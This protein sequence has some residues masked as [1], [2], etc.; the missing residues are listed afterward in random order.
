MSSRHW[1]FAMHK[2][3]LNVALALCPIGA[4]ALAIGGSKEVV[5]T[6][7]FLEVPGFVFTFFSVVGTA[8]SVL[9]LVAF[10]RFLFEPAGSV[11]ITVCSGF[12]AMYVREAARRTDLPRLHM[13][14]SSHFGRDVPSVE[15]M[16]LWLARCATIF[17]LIHRVRRNEGLSELTGTFKFIPL[18]VAGVR[19]L[20]LGRVT[21]STFRPEHVCSCRERAA[22]CYVGDVVATTWFGRGVVMAN[23]RDACSDAVGRGLV[24]FARPL[25]GDGLRLMI[26]YGF[27]QVSDGR[28]SP[29]IGK[30]CRLNTANL[31]LQRRPRLT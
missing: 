31:K 14:Y 3:P 15:R 12:G 1:G 29:E 10:A 20:E 6:L 19:D 26:R 16:R 2:T 13:L 8:L 18:T 27:I 4:A 22:G 11:L 17:T 28:S 30:V 5:E 25:T 7:M 9:G 21:G 24:I 23:L